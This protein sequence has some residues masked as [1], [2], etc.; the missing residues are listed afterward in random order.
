[1]GRPPGLERMFEE[2]IF[3][4]GEMFLSSVAVA[5]VAHGYNWTPGIAVLGMTS[6]GPS[7]TF[8]L[9]IPYRIRLGHAVVVLGTLGR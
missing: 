1:M 3:E 5:T 7:S 6:A 2:R 4:E 8:C 9:S